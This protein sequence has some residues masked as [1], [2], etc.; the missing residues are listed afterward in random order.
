[1]ATNSKSSNL[2][3]LKPAVGDGPS[4]SKP[5]IDS[6][7]SKKKI[8]GGSIRNSAPDSKNRSIFSSS[9]KMTKKTSAQTKDDKKTVKRTREKKVYSLAGQKFDV[10][11]ERE[12]LRIFY[13]SL[14]K[15]IPSSEMAEFWLMEHG[16][17][18]PERSRKAY[19]KKQRK[20]KQIRSGTPIKSPPPSTSSRPESSKKPQPVPKNGEVKSKKRIKE[21]SN[22]EDDFVL[23]HKW[24]RG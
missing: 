20:Q 16:M 3:K 2:A 5:R 8:V 17:L 15:Q 13:E 4:S 23:S 24:R 6:S 14:S 21:D 9:S 12:P 18:S 1:M 22:D 10:P 19:E 7:A 11:E